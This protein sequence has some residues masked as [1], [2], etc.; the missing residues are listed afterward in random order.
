MKKI[1]LCVVLVALLVTLAAFALPPRPMLPCGVGSLPIGE[2][3][4]NELG[5][6]DGRPVSGS[7]QAFYCGR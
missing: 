7:L 5:V 1:V 3:N 2:E 4:Y 6:L